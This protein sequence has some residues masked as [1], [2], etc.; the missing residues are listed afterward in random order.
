MEQ[1]QL[2]RPQ[3]FFGKMMGYNAKFL[4]TC[5]E[6]ERLMVI[7]M[8]CLL[9]MTFVSAG[10]G[11]FI[12][13][14][15]FWS[16][17]V[18]IPVGLFAACYIF[19]IDL[20][21]GA[22]EW[23]LTYFLRRPGTRR[24]TMQRV[25][26]AIRGVMLCTFSYATSIA[27]AMCMFYGAI[28][29][30][31]QA[32]IREQNFAITQQFDAK[33]TNLRQQRLGTEMGALQQQLDLVKATT[34][35]VDAA[36]A[37]AAD[38]TAKAKAADEEANRELHGGNGYRGGPGPRWRAARDALRAAQVDAG[39]ETAKCE[40]FQ[41]R[42]HQAGAG[43]EEARGRLREAEQAILPELRQI[44]AERQATL[45]KNVSDPLLDRIALEKVMDDPVKG[46]TA[47]H[48]HWL[49]MAVLML[50]EIGYIVVRVVF[51]PPSI[52]SL[53]LN[54]ETKLRAYRERV[55]Y[56][57]KIADLDGQRPPVDFGYGQA[58][59]PITGA[60][61]APVRAAADRVAPD[62]C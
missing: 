61:K 26:L 17:W 2:S 39:R 10:M 29:N 31:R 42:L 57:R 12:F 41:A 14:S 8:G 6:H 49:I 62:C 20:S 54:K 51:E 5:E 37:A 48:F 36:C 13:A 7:R 1:P 11:W 19:L 15:R 27:V 45:V 47:R 30:Q 24:S 50:V 9:S 53:L 18:A 3:R 33:E 4:A 23:A 46:A 16:L 22:S 32:D 35:E 58:W 25:G 28:D 56:E 52:H 34:P 40:A 59:V 44:E 60:P 43:A 38:A 55:D 21:I